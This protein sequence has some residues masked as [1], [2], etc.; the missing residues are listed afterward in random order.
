MLQEEN[1]VNK[2]DMGVKSQNRFSREI[3]HIKIMA[4][5]NLA[6]AMV[7]SGSAVVV[8]KMMVSSLPTFLATELGILIGMLILLPLTFLIKREA[9][10]LDWK[11]HAVLF[12]QA[13]CGVFL[14][15][16][17]TLIGLTYTSAATSGLITSASPIIVVILAYI[18]LKERLFLNQWIG[19]TCVVIGL[20]VINL[21]TYYG[22]ESGHSSIKGNALIFAAVICEALFSILSKIKCKPMSA[23]YRTTII[24]FDAFILLLPFAIRD[25]MGFDFSKVEFTT[26]L[27]IAYYGVF[28][29][30]LSYIFWFR[31]IEHVPA[32]NAAVFTSIVPIS[33]ILLSVVIL[34]ER[35][36]FAHWIGMICI[37]V[38]I[39]VFSLY[40]EKRI[41]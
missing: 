14:Y 6:L 31:G 21:Y 22:V 41:L 34:K 24:V 11:S 12:A 5:I 19:V 40:K 13:F 15:R 1:K 17:F 39:W 35:I 4:Y 37:I 3:D 9:R 18:I 36:M 2:I 16:V 8:S 27:C 23:L 10:Q 20:L 28:V 25:A 30:F 29:T 26:I 38:G 33:S 32:S 7:I